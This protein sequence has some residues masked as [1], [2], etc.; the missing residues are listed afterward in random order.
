MQSYRRGGDAR[1]GSRAGALKGALF[2]G[3]AAAGAVGVVRLDGWLRSDDVLPLRSVAVAGVSGERAREVVAYAEVSQGEPLL[4]V[5]L[6][7]VKARVEQHPFVDTASV[8]RVPPD[9]LEIEVR[10]RRPRA[11]VALDGVLYLVDER[12]APQKRAMPGDGL[13]LPVITGIG[14][15]AFAGTFTGGEESGG[16]VLPAPDALGVALRV[17]ASHEAAGAPG[18]ALA[19]VRMETAE[20]PVAVLADGTRVVLGEGDYDEK[21]A[22]LS[23]VMEALSRQGKGA[24]R[25][26]LDDDRRPERVA[27]RLRARPEMGEKPEG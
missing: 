13:D 10:E 24:E 16:A 22:R 4:G 11:L 3:V 14:A 1:R 9:G 25:V 2:V 12:G 8:R 19:E 21:M 20:R 26:R 18:G 17:L 27:V 15:D 23:R 5:D 7:V 6:D